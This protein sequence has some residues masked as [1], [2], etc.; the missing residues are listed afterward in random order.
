MHKGTINKK[1][2]K[3]LTPIWLN[4]YYDICSVHT[5]FHTLIFMA[6]ICSPYKDLSHK[7]SQLYIADVS[8]EI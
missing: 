4:Y 5:K 1:F 6:E 2:L 3:Q 7:I 8:S